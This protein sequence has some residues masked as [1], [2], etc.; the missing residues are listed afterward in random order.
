MTTTALVQRQDEWAGARPSHASLSVCCLTGGRYLPRVAGILGLLRPLADEI[1]VGVDDRARDSAALLGDVADRILLFAH[2]EPADRPIPWLVR[3]CT[4]DWVFNIDDDEVPSAALLHELP[5]LIDRGDVTHCWVARRWLYPDV[6]AFLDEPPWNTEYQLRLFKADDRSLRFTDEFH[7]PVVCSGPARFVEAPLWHL[8]TALTSREERQQKALRYERSRRGMRIGAFSHNTGLYLP[9]L[10]PEPAVSG[11]PPREVA[12]IKE[13]LL[14]PARR[15]DGVTIE[16]PSRDAVEREWPGPPHRPTLYDASIALLRSLPPLVGGV[17]QTI[18]LRIEN[19][20][21]CVWRTGESIM[22]A[23]RWNDVESIRTA[24]PADVLP[25]DSAVVPLHVIPPTVAGAHLLEIDLVHEHVRWFDRSLRLVV[26]VRGRRRVLVAGRADRVAAVL[27]VIALRPEL[28]PVTVH[29]RDDP[30]LGH[31]HVDGVGRF[32]FGP[33]GTAGWRALPRALQLVARARREGVPYGVRPLAEAIRGSELVI[34]VDDDRVTGAPP[35][36]DRARVLVLVATARVQ[37]VPVVRV[38]SAELSD[39][40]VDRLL[41]RMVDALTETA[42][43][44][45]LASAFGP[46]AADKT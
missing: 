1:V 43:D 39:S 46:L 17:Q 9:E 2:A 19:R 13:V 35:T 26:D 23:T 7:R 41:Q 44:S 14:T 34:L 27:D 32:L 37:R 36:R 45:A 15:R 6:S 8:D 18:D 40:R 24:L 29:E 38:G 4:G 22:L 21:D 16:E 42:D 25:G 5:G 30:H 20:G 12:R 33:N 3:Q 28:E 31:P 10:R 11:V